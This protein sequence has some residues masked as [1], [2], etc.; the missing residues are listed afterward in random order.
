M[1]PV[2]L[3]SEHKNMCPKDRRRQC[4]IS[5]TPVYLDE[6][7][8]RLVE[9]D[10]CFEDVPQK[11]GGKLAYGCRREI[12]LLS[13]TIFELILHLKSVGSMSNLSR[14]SVLPNQL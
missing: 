7:T 13:W 6:E 12:D 9:L 5:P 3:T 1:L 2:Y 11:L 8:W 4:N 10:K 14:F